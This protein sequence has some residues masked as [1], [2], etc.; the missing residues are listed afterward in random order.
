MVLYDADCRLCAGWARRL[1]PALRRAGFQLAPL[2]RGEA[3]T[4]P[5]EMEVQ[6]SD[7]R[8]LGGA[9]GA[10]EIARRVWWAR[11]LFALSKIPGAMP[12]LRAAYRRLA[13]KRNCLTNHC[14]LDKNPRRTRPR[15]FFELP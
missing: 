7:G 14:G 15:V 3:G 9:D 4:E 11:P 13:A 2:P 5:V 6:A 10:V 8:R 1:E 12:L